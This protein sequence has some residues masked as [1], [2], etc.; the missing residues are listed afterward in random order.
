M[1]IIKRAIAIVLMLFVMP[2]CVFSEESEDLGLDIEEIRRRIYDEDSE[3][4]IEMSLGDSDVSLFLAGS[5]GGSLQLNPGLSFSPLGT[6]I[7]SPEVPFFSQEADITLSLWINDKWFVEANFLDDSN[8][9]TY[10]AGYEGFPDEFVRYAVIGNTG[11]NFPAF[12]YLDLGGDSFSSFGF[13]GNFAAG[14]FD[15]HALFRYDSAARESRTFSGNMERTYNYVQPQNPVRGISFLLPDTNIESEI[16]VYI[17]DADGTLSDS[18]DRRW[19]IASLSEY[20]V[21]RV[22]GFLELNIKPGGMVAVS[23]S[24]KGKDDPWNYSYEDYLN[25]IEIFDW[26]NYDRVDFPGENKI[27]EISFNSAPA[28]VIYAPGIFSAFERQNLYEIPSGTSQQAALVTLSS[29][30]QINGFEIVNV[31]NSIFELLKEG[32]LNRRHAKNLWPLAQE[33]PEIYIPGTGAFSGDV[34]LR[35]IN[36]LNTNGYFIG[37]DVIPGSVQ[38]WRNGIQDANFRFDSSSGEVIISGDVKSNEIIRITY[39]KSSQE[40]RFGS[41]AA[42]AGAIYQHSSD[43]FTAQAAL[44]LRINLEDDSFTQADFS[45][46]GSVG[47]GAKA[48]WTYD[49]F[50]ANIAGGLAFE[51]TDTTGLYRAAG[52]EG[53]EAVLA[54]PV[55]TAFISNPFITGLTAVNPDEVP[56]DLVFRNYYDTNFLGSTLMQITWNAPVISGINKPYPAKDSLLG[57]SQV[58]AAEFILNENEW[59]GF[60]VPVLNPEILSGAGVIEIPFRFYG[61]NAVPDDLI[62][63]VQIGSLSGSDF[64]FEENPNLIW[65][66]QLY[67]SVSDSSAYYSHNEFNTSARIASFQLSDADRARLGDARAFRLV[68]VNQNGDEIQGRVL[69]APPIVRGAAFR[70]A[71][72]DNSTDI[73]AGNNSMVSAVESIDTTLASAF[74][75][76]INRLHPNNEVQRVLEIKWEEMPAGI[77]AGVDGRISNLPLANYSA[78]SFFVKGPENVT[79]D[80]TIS[81]Y[82]TS[83]PGSIQN[84]Q[85]EVHIPIDKFPA[86]QWKKIT[87]RYQGSNTGVSIDGINVPEARWE[88]KPH[89][90]SFDSVEGMASYIAFFINPANSISSLKPGTISIDE[91]ILEDAAMIY[92]MNVSSSLEYSRPGAIISIGGVSLLSDLSISAAVDME[93]RSEI[94]WNNFYSG[95]AGRTALGISFF[96]ARLTGNL[97][98]ITSE[99]IFLWGAGHSISGSWNN[100]SFRETFSAS[101]RQ[102]TARHNINFSYSPN[103][104]AGFNADVLYDSSRLRQSWNLDF[105]YRSVNEYIPSLT[106]NTQALWISRNQFPDDDNYLELWFNSLHPLVPD[107]GSGAESRRTSVGIVITER[108]APVGAV[109]SFNGGANFS[110]ANSVTRLDNSL[111]LDIPVVFE[112]TSITFRAGRSFRRQLD[113]SGRDIFD[114]I[115]KF[116]ESINDSLPLWGIFPGYSLFSPELGRAMDDVVNNSSS[117]DLARLTSFNDHFSARF[118]LPSVYDLSSFIIP[119]RINL[120]IERTLEQRLDTRTDVLN[121][122]GGFGFSS[123][124]MFGIMGHTPL[125]TFY[126]SDEYSHAIEASLIF[127]KNEGISWRVQSV[128]N[129]GFRGFTGGVLNFTNTLALH[130]NG[131]WTEKFQAGWETPTENSLISVFYNWIVS[132]ISGQSSWLFLSS[133]LN[134]EYEQFRRESLELSFENSQGNLRWS[135]SAGHEEVVRIIGRLTF[136]GFLKLKL[137][138]DRARDFFTFDVL[139]GTTLRIIF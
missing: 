8:R 68:A 28:L 67:P 54:I 3:T 63:I 62:L 113:F 104:Y 125:F 40:T 88:Y 14:G 21:S 132:K 81:F 20:A 127:S 112:R 117:A 94:D 51:R 41:I 30:E 57:D 75:E 53:N 79:G 61:F 1:A 24:N 5:W 64:Y 115:D 22:Q 96:G 139:L 70:A 93:G 116:F 16:T 97:S 84:S 111:F 103:F 49:F 76:I 17:E 101:F 121:L 136:T 31:E 107:S 6:G 27:Y 72:Y 55:D 92:R 46:V 44:G 80:E 12:P 102:N 36:Y 124:N 37:S 119:S 137:T 78:L 59:T 26:F 118:I 108:T 32:E 131:N 19:R 105:G 86:G 95:M 135:V 7:A 83:G 18:T 10:S 134:S 47:L 39:L 15:I 73:V 66:R 38:V 120:R 91:I 34:V 89:G 82:V 4:L 42:G 35:F 114:D 123:I 9:N 71:T 56:V 48:E 65:E 25:E 98:F 100:F 133:F 60:Q 13:Y 2:I 122:T 43:T 29:G 129:A 69:L 23:Y 50:K 77:S 85:L 109:L 87:I 126:Q 45:S 33:Y 130:S 58:I 138:D 99:N 110:A 128:I 90:I 106:V 52:M 74:P 11:L